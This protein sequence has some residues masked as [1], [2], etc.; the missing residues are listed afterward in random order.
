MMVENKLSKLAKVRSF[1]DI[2][3]KTAPKGEQETKRSFT[4]LVNSEDIS[5]KNG[6]KIEQLSFDVLKPFYEHPFKLYTGKKLDDMV[7]SIKENGIM[8]PLIVRRL[9][10]GRFEIL[11]GHNR[12]N[13]AKL[14]R[15]ETVPAIIK[16]G[17]SEAEAKIIVT[18]T[19]FIQRSISEMFPSELARSLKM[20]LEACKEAKQKQALINGVEND[21]KANEIGSCEQKATL[22]LRQ[23]SRDILAE[24][25]SMNRET[26]RHYIR[27]NRL[28]PSL[29]EMVDEGKIS[30]RAAV[31]LSYLKETE[32]QSVLEILEDNNY[33][34][35]MNKAET[36]RHLSEIAKLDE[37]KIIAVLSGEYNKKKKIE[38]PD[39]K[40]ILKISYKRL[41]PYFDKDT[42]IKTMEEEIIKAL[43]FY[44]QA[45][46]E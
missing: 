33:K 44:K 36:L 21:E 32:Q 1:E 16:D 26:I 28:I 18:D 37:N 23:Q 30:L 10:D 39:E 7:E 3:A 4:G 17:I 45:Q 25:N 42:D 6:N 19:N 38:K 15:L 31:D 5:E 20:Q 35:D 41:T 40:K 14:A 43:E 2:F 11:S 46:T 22:L 24:N 34:V 8:T 12:F 29:L 27:L 13:A 9:D